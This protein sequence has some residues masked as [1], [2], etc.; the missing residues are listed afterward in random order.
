ME[1]IRPPKLKVPLVTDY[2][3]ER[4][5]FS[6]AVYFFLSLSFSCEN[7]LSLPT[8]FFRCLPNREEKSTTV[9][10]NFFKS[11]MNGTASPGI[12]IIRRDP[13]S[14]RICLITTAEEFPGEVLLILTSELIGE[15]LRSIHDM[16]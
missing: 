7:F 2:H 16:R 9:F 8:Q 6:A 11:T 15:Q 5:S 14:G 4:A 10:I 3:M 13:I 12:F 1:R